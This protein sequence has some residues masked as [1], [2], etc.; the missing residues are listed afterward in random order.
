[1][2][3]EPPRPYRIERQRDGKPVAAQKPAQ[4][5]TPAP[6][7]HDHLDQLMAA[8]SRVESR[9]T[10]IADRLDDDPDTH[11]NFTAPSADQSEGGGPDFGR[12]LVRDFRSISAGNRRI[13]GA[14]DEL[15][16]VIKSTEQATEEIL[17]A[18]E[19]IDEVATDLGQQLANI[20]A[21]EHLAPEMNTIRD[22]VVRIFQASSFQDLTGQRLSNVTQI[23]NSVESRLQDVERAMGVDHSADDS[24]DEEVAC[25][26]PNDKHFDESGLLN[27]PA[28][29]GISQDDIDKLFG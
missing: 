26:D 12:D 2:A 4:P 10:V 5:K 11:A 13:D 22:Q 25:G 17:T 18:C 14:A 3:Y 19:A 8:I 9:I 15:T 7:T 24:G 28:D 16:S 20:D 6:S 21:A 1:M 29:D 27:G 23:L